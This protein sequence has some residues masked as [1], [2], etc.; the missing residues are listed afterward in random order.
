VVIAAVDNRYV[1]FRAS[2]R[3]GSEKTAEATAD[4][5]DP[6]A[7]GRWSNAHRAALRSPSHLRADKLGIKKYSPPRNTLKVSMPCMRRL[8]GALGT[9]KLAPCQ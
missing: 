6:M 8:T 9:V 5:G 1:N 4:N 2:Q 7:A 3:P